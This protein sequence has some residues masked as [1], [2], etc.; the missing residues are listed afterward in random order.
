MTKILISK[1]D[2]LPERE[3]VFCFY[4]RN[5]QPLYVGAA[6]NI[7]KEAHKFL[8]EENLFSIETK[9]AEV[10][11]L[12]SLEIDLVRLFAG[13][14]RL[15]KP[16]YNISL[17]GEKLYPHFKIT[18]ENFPRLLV[19]RRIETDA[20]AYF[21]AFLPETGAR[22]MLDFLNR[23]FRLRSCAIEIDGKFPLPC[24]QFYEQ[25]CVAPCVESLCVK[26]TYDGFAE[27]LRL[28]L[29]NKRENLK[30]FLLQKIDAA[31]EVLDFET[32]AYWRDFLLNVQNIWDEKN[33]QIWLDDAI[34]NF[35]IEEK[36]EQIFIRLVTQR[37]KKILGKRV[38]VFARH[39]YFTTET[40]LSQFLWQFY[41]FH[42]PKEIRLTSDF[43]SRKF[44]AEVL[45]RRENRTININIL[46]QN[47][48][49]INIRR[50]FGRTKF[51]F[52]FKQIKPPINFEDIQRQLKLEFNLNSLPQRIECFDVAHISGTN[53]V[54]AKIVWEKG[55]FLI[56]ENR[57]WFDAGKNELETLEKGIEKS[58]EEEENL[59]DL[60]L[61][62]GGKPQLKAALKALE[63]TNRKKSFVI[64]AVKPP[65]RHSEIS[66][67]IS[68][69]GKVFEMKP[70]SEAMQLLVKL[71]D[72]AHD[73]AN[74]IHRTQRNTAHFYETANLLPSLDE[75]E[76]RLLLQKFGS[77]KK[78][79][80]AVQRDLIELFNAEKSEKIF[81]ELNTENPERILKIKPL[82]VPIRFDAPG[83]DA[84]DLQPLRLTR[85]K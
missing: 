82:I 69:T 37:G 39:R 74:H 7:K 57:Y 2:A 60:I 25:R 73:L 46:N 63:K 67:F 70:K 83:G 62:D 20:A 59:P 27:L 79:K 75:I 26:K 15:K 1:I 22:I 35:E 34:D 21:G 50:A 76:R 43:P 29:Q 30:T 5:K 49:K 77:I 84:G 61:I 10:D 80:Q 56:D 54:A 81:I 4:N 66:H 48:K 9:I 42:A 78:I 68:E 38:F 11:F 58:F 85:G 64:A 31:S 16:L 3:G 6:G 36:D 51:E 24:T 71:R 65:N 13:T 8:L 14:I 45:S 55:K 17:A 23:I 41:Q 52:E 53:F 47:N 18:L 28:F 72:E 33:R 12:E 32:A 44:L 19:T 40:I